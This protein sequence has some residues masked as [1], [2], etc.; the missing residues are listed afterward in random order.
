M[1]KLACKTRRIIDKIKSRDVIVNEK[2]YII[3]SNRM[4]FDSFRQSSHELGGQRVHLTEDEEVEERRN[5]TC[6]LLK[7]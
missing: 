5:V 1:V 6:G 3:R 7:C 2:A 4:S